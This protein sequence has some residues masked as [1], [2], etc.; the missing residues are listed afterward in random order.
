MEYPDYDED[1]PTCYTLPMLA[2]MAAVVAVVW[3]ASL[4]GRLGSLLKLRRGLSLLS[5]GRDIGGESGRH[6]ETR[7][8]T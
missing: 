6:N 2:I 1:E 4:A 5:H 3:L 8:R 7:T